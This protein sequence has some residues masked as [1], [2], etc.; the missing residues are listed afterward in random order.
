MIEIG[1]LLRQTRESKDLSLAD[2]E[3]ETRIRQRYLN[4]LESGDWDEL[5]N[6]VAVRGFL[7]RYATFLGL[8]PEELVSQFDEQVTPA[9]SSASLPNDDAASSS[10]YKPIDLDLY[11]AA[12]RRSRLARR[13]LG[14]AIF[15][16][17]LFVLA[18]LLFTYGWPYLKGGAE[19]GGSLIATATL[20]PEGQIPTA[21]ILA[22]TA[23]AAP[24][25][26]AAPTDEGSAPTAFTPTPGPTDTPTI[27]PSLILTPTPAE[28][29]RLRVAVTSTAWL[30]I[31][32]DGNVQVESLVDPGF[33]QEFSAYQQLEFLTGNAGGVQLTLDGAPMPPLGEVGEIVVF[34]WM[35]RDG[36]IVE[37]TPTPLPTPN[38]ATDITPEPTGSPAVAETPTPDE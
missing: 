31:V 34:N 28:S 16:I 22:K 8:D 17:P 19:G 18:Y 36:E 4:A 35:I 3:A 30:R 5:P 26:T 6:P 38:P 12:T 1:Q 23:T 32:T 9:A 14:L 10:D 13:I 27:T 20:P 11:G 24:A 25:V 15:V 7:R 29:I 2:V 37:I 33:E 21:P